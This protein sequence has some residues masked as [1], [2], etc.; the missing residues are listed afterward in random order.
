MAL[1]SSSD[2]SR[3][4]GLE[5]IRAHFLAGGRLENEDPEVLSQSALK[6]FKFLPTGERQAFLHPMTEKASRL[7]PTEKYSPGARS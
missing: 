1:M 3:G 4:Y 7:C 6:F 5:I 2:K